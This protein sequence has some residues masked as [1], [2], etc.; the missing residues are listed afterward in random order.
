MSKPLQTKILNWEKHIEVVV[1]VG[2]PGI[3]EPVV[4]EE[5]HILASQPH[6]DNLLVPLEEPAR[7]R[8]PDIADA[9][10]VGLRSKAQLEWRN[11]NQSVM[12]G[13]TKNLSWMAFLIQGPSNSHCPQYEQL[14][15][16]RLLLN[17]CKNIPA[18]TVHRTNIRHT[19]AEACAS[20]PMKTLNQVRLLPLLLLLCHWCWLYS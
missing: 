17:L 15:L 16:I 20:N 6:Q 19:T 4:P 12:N 9:T 3:S 10:A 18:Y 14:I 8:T 7:E 11:I 13:T 1:D 2:K 5:P